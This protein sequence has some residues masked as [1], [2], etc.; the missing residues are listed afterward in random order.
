MERH[1]FW[2]LSPY[3]HVCSRYFH[4]MT[5]ICIAINSCY[6]NS[7][8]IILAFLKRIIVIIAILCNI[9]NSLTCIRFILSS[10]VTNIILALF[11]REHKKEIQWTITSIFHLFTIGGRS[12]VPPGCQK[13]ILRFWFSRWNPSSAS[14]TKLFC[15]HNTFVKGQLL[16][17]CWI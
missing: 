16:C 9:N 17:L 15:D 5:L 7:W 6:V 3:L 8:M 14:Q 12:S 4:A 13:C 11:S 1:H 10:S 2:T